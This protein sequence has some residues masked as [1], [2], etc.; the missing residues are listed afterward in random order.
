MRKFIIYSSTASTDSKIGDLRSAGRWD[1]LLHSIISS[2]FASNE[3]R[4][5]VELHI[6]AM[7]PPNAP[8]H[9]LLKYV[10]GNT[11]SKKNLKRFIEIA[12]KKCKPKLTLE[13]HPGVFVDD[14]TISTVVEDEFALN[15]E[16]FMLDFNGSHIKNVSESK[17]KNGTFILGDFDGFDKKTKKFLKKNTNRISLGSQMYFTSQAITI[18]NYELDNLD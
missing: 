3:F 7:G 14:K 13:I 5:D 6:I 16:V 18:I 4:N 9:I 1:I 15:R 10:K 11:L 17:L 2:L 12:L 8:R